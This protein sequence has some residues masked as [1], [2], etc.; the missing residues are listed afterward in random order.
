MIYWIFIQSI[1]QSTHRP[2][3]N[4]SNFKHSIH[5]SIEWMCDTN[6]SIDQLLDVSFLLLTLWY[7]CLDLRWIRFKSIL[8]LIEDTRCPTFTGLTRYSA[9]ELD[10]PFQSN[11][12]SSLQQC[13]AFCL[14]EQSSPCAFFTYFSANSTCTI[15]PAIKPL[16]SQPR[17]YVGDGDFLQNTCSGPQS[18]SLLSV[19]GDASSS[20]SATFSDNTVNSD[21]SQRQPAADGHT[22]RGLDGADASVQTV[23]TSGTIFT[24]STQAT[25]T[26]PVA[27]VTSPATLFNLTSLSQSPPTL[28]TPTASSTP[29]ALPPPNASLLL[30]ASLAH[31]QNQT[32]NSSSFISAIGES[33]ASDSLAALMANNSQ[34]GLGFSDGGAD[35]GCR[36]TRTN[37][38]IMSAF[39]SAAVQQVDLNGC[40]GQCVAANSCLAFSYSL[41]RKTCFMSA[42]SLGKVPGML[43]V[44]S[45]DDFVF[46]EKGTECTDSKSLHGKTLGGGG[47][48]LVL[49]IL[50]GIFGGD[51]QFALSIDQLIDW[52]INWV[53]IDQSI[54]RLI[55][56][57][58]DWLIEWLIDWLIDCLIVE[59]Y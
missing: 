1:N 56:W 28:A 35:F 27:S 36:F 20:S 30:S 26:T 7:Y 4:Q 55:D 59:L 11:D 54:D 40:E 57:L 46:Y 29:L 23:A 47:G 44:T 18:A 8:C 33:T 21:R 12:P 50:I 25:P 13:E 48:S 3:I 51:R 37:G 31:L 5:Q 17:G 6:L 58:I 41:S 42:V 9:F 14:Q 16:P 38:R 2:E 52:S 19:S 15:A 34:N 53:I 10:R 45:G 22:D 39:V 43:D 32:S 49:K 24:V